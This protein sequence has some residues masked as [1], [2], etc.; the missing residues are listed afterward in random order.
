MPRSHRLHTPGTP[1]PCPRASIGPQGLGLLFLLTSLVIQSHAAPA[2]TSRQ[3]W[4]ESFD[5]VWR[6]VRDKHFD[7]NYAGVDWNQAR[8]TYTKRLEG[9]ENEADLYA[10]L[11]A[12]LGELKQTH[13][14]IVPPDVLP[15]SGDHSQSEG[16]PG[17]QFTL[18]AG[19]A[20]V[21]RV[22]KG[23]SA[24]KAGV[25][26]GW[27]VESVEGQP[28]D[29]LLEPLN[30]SPMSH[31]LKPLYRHRL[32]E[33]KLEGKLESAVKV[34]FS[35]GAGKRREWVLERSAR[36]QERSQAMGHFPP[37]PTEFEH[38]KLRGN[39]AYIR[40]NIFVI[41]QMEKIRKAIRASLGDRGMIIDLRGNPGGVAGMAMGMGG[42]LLPQEAS[43]GTMRMRSGHIHFAV[44]PQE[45]RFLGPLVILVDQQSASTSEIFAAGLQDLKRAR[46]VGMPTAGAAL[47][48]MFE[49]LPTGALF[50]YA[51][52]D[53]RT[54]K[55]TLVEGRGVLPDV[56]IEGRREDWLRGRDTQLEAALE[57]I[58]TWIRED[59]I[60]AP[61][62][63]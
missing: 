1:C 63:R 60:R 4:Q 19:E 15:S 21:T 39:V 56:R 57:E 45:K 6:T 58:E 5:K 24:W 36:N 2:S 55:G 11:G 28:I 17:F 26:N 20:V 40:F 61:K 10:L 22:L 30:R 34:V 7:T 9:I 25:K 54:P 29:R 62:D 41:S 49:K 59:R 32:I 31:A 16:D 47:P 52:G 50:Q 46:I 35:N 14:G 43:L 38:R 44:F 18:I 33:S 27:V 53:F 3:A 37:Q 23:T 51:F 12:M 13:F 8:V 42:L 48:S